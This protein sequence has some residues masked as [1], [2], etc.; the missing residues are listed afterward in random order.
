MMPQA[1][2]F[3]KALLF[4]SCLLGTSYLV[5]ATVSNEDIASP[6]S[7]ATLEHEHPGC[8]SNARCSAKTGRH[9]LEWSKLVTSVKLMKNPWPTLERW[10]AKNGIPFEFWSYR[11]SFDDFSPMIFNS[12]CPLH[13]PVKPEKENPI[14]F[15]GETFVSKIKNT[16]AITHRGERIIPVGPT[17]DVYFDQV[18]VLE[19]KKISS[20]SVPRGEIPLNLEQNALVLIRDYEGFYY[21]LKI[22]K[23]GKMEIVGPPEK[24]ETERV[25]CPEELL[26]A[27]EA[28]S[29]E[30]KKIYKDKRCLKMKDRIVLYG[31]GC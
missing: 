27:F 8:V 9:R 4:G 3:F 2:Q 15:V 10:R 31:V 5:A 21:G 13:T 30:Y 11:E 19:K 26:K 1:L 28:S 17:L 6:P 24:A 29:T 12:P 16:A 7:L 23:D 20:Y 14:I 18:L 25:E 22:F